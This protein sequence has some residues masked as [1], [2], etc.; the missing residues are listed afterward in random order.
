IKISGQVDL[1]GVD[2]ALQPFV[3][4]FSFLSNSARPPANT[5]ALIREHTAGTSLSPVVARVP[6]DPTVPIHPLAVNGRAPASHGRLLPGLM[7]ALL[8]QSARAEPLGE[9]GAESLVELLAR[10]NLQF[11]ASVGPK[12]HVHALRL[13][14]TAHRLAARAREHL[15]GFE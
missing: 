12:G 14:S 15:T 6:S 1:S 13:A 3:R 7:R 8:E 9:A 2:A 4:S 10:Y 5:A 11:E